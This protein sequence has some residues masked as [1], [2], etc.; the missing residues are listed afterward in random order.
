MTTDL[1]IPEKDDASFKHSYDWNGHSYKRVKKQF[2]KK[3]CYIAF[4]SLNE[5]T[6]RSH[7]SIFER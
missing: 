4:D 7:E 1:S 3:S 5:G 6:K 2:K